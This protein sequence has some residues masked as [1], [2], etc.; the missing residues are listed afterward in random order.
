MASVLNSVAGY[1][2]WFRFWHKSGMELIFALSFSSKKLQT[3]FFLLRKN[4]CT[5]ARFS[6]LFKFTFAF[7]PFIWETSSV[8][9][10][11]S[12]IFSVHSKKPR[13]PCVS[14]FYLRK[15]QILGISPS[16]SCRKQEANIHFQV[17][18]WKGSAS[19]LRL[20]YVS[21]TRLEIKEEGSDF[22]CLVNKT[23][24]GW[25]GILSGRALLGYLV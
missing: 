9:K 18:D 25:A 24:G 13:L 16:Y 1:L 23:F 3:Y 20:C 11:W 15:L 5:W 14:N 10:P 7:F 12:P 17:E 22:Y 4:E 19:V 21:S 2:D 6:V 8:L